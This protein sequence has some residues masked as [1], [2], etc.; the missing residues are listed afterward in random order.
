MLALAL[1]TLTGVAG[2]RTLA[3]QV[4]GNPVVEVKDVQIKGLGIEGGALDVLLD[5][6][7]PNEFRMDATRISY[8]V[9]VD[10][11]PVANGEIDQRVTLTEKGKSQVTVPVNFTYNEIRSV[12]SQFMLKGT[13]DYRVTGH[14]TYMTPFGNLTRPYSGS[15]RVNGFQ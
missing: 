11:I 6:Y 15:G 5:V 9:W 13:L 3:K 10:S 7:N 4:M 1:V 8:Q 12:I 2:C 14:L